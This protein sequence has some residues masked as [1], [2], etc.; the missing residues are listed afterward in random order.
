MAACMACFMGACSKEDG[1]NPA[2]SE[3]GQNG[4]QGEDGSD[5]NPD[6]PTPKDVEFLFEDNFALTRLTA[7]DSYPYYAWTEPGFKTWWDSANAGYR[8]AGIKAQPMDYPAAPGLNIGVDGKNCLQL[9]TRE[10]GAL[11]ALAG[12]RIAAG[13]LFTG[14]FDTQQAMSNT[15]AATRMGVPYAHKPIKMSGYYKYQPGDRLQDKDGNEITGERDA[16]DIYCIVY[17][18]VDEQGKKVQLDA[19]NILTSSAVVGVGHIQKN[20]IDF[21]NQ[22]VAFNI[23]VAYTATVDSKDIENKLYST[24]IVFTS[25]ARGGEF[26]GAPGSTL[27]IDNVKLESEY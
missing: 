2:S 13:A 23:P 17:K 18:N 24:A 16:P 27:W 25:S 4:Q 7:G 12:M 19:S 20:E 11:G 21:S 14:S 1:G 15:L 22:W 9:T 3:Q 8:M 5:D 6:E 10:T 26:I